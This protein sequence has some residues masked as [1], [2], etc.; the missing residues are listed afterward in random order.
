MIN[1]KSYSFYFLILFIGFQGISGLI[2]G[3]ALMIDPT[4][5]LIQLPV[6]ML[7]GSLFDNFLIPGVILLT[8]LGIFPMF[9]LYGLTKKRLWSWFGAFT[10]SVALIIWIGVE[11][12]IVG[13]HP[14]PP[15]QLIY[16]LLGIIMLGLVL[17]P[18]VRHT[19]NED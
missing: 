11:I 1:L 13:Y 5:A 9:V 12:W 4:G 8:I 19:L 10:V 16:G 18:S 17:M 2:G 15:L 14:K 6:S 3:A 7:E